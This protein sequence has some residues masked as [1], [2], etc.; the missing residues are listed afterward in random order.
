MNDI[1]RTSLAPA[2]RVLVAANAQAVLTTLRAGDGHPYGSLVEYLALADGDVLMLLSR[3]A[4][5]RRYLEADPRASVLVAGE[6]L[7]QARVTLL[8]RV[9]PEA[10]K[11]GWRDA[12]LARHPQAETY[13]DFA[14]FDFFRLRVAEARY[15]AGFGRMGWIAGENY[16][17]AG[18]DRSDDSLSEK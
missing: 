15:I 16:R 7:S 17:A 2:A 13:I 18:V 9:E 3:L 10:D 5:H 12:Y 4:E 1:R 6:A 14:D 11:A 8:G